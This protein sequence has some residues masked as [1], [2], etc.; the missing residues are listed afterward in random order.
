MRVISHPA[1]FKD[2]IGQELGVSDW[3]DVTQERINT[4]AE[5]TGTFNG[6]TS[7]R[8]GHKRNCLPSQQ[9]LM[10]F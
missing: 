2:L 6:S 9:L 3:V 10:D 8:Q 7:M 1:E 5:A 4:F